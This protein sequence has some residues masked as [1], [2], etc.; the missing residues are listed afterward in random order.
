[1]PQQE[2]PRD[3]SKRVFVKKMAYVAPTVLTMTAVAS[4]SAAAS[5]PSDPRYLGPAEK[6]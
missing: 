3:L 5:G 1:M 6:R 2:Q 4:L